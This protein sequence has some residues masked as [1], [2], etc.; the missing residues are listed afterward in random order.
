MSYCSKCGHKNEEEA[1]FCSKCGT[2]LTGSKENF[3]KEF[4]NR[5]EEDCA[6]GKHGRPPIFW[7]VIV[8]LVGL[9]ILVEFVLKNIEGLNLPTWV[10]DF[11]FWWVLAL[12]V[13]IAIIV[14]GIR[15]IFRK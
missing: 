4:E 10:Q 7:G 3:E 6:G 9:W 2:A 5:C 14:T 15:I 13:A 12:L 8:I 1:E 11:N